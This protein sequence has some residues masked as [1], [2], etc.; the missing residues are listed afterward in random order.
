MG[1]GEGRLRDVHDRT[2]GRGKCLF[3]R[4]LLTEV[5]VRGARV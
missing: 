4:D 5:N 3:E 2:E 1:G